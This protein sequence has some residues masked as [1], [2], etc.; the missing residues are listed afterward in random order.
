MSR[1]GFDDGKD[2]PLLHP[3]HLSLHWQSLEHQESDRMIASMNDLKEVFESDLLQTTCTDSGELL[4]LWSCVAGYAESLA[5]HKQQRYHIFPLPFEALQRL[6]RKEFTPKMN[7]SSS[8]ESTSHR[9]IVKTVA[10]IIWSHTLTKPNTRDEIHANSVY[11][12]LRGRIDRKSLDCFGAALTTIAGCHIRGLTSSLL[13]LSEDHAYERHVLESGAIGTCE[14]AVPGTT[15]A[16]QAKRGREIAETFPKDALLTPQTS[17][18]YMASNPVVC[19]SIPMMLV[20]VI[21]NINCT[22]EKQQSNKKCLASGQLYDFKRDMLWILYDQGHM[23]K[24]PFGLLELG[25]CEEHRGS[26][27]SEEWVKV[28][29]IPELILLNEKLYWDA[30]H[31]NKKFYDE[32]QVYPYFCKSFHYGRV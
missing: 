1:V 8:I 26:S 29:Q 10:N 28:D 17:W 9:E 12:W 25:D 21:A 32:A 2:V 4:A 15:K 11:V 3:P 18:L 27:R 20:A 16:A 14:V 13:A 30:I 22:I 24:F 23:A 31:I 19:D 5:T 7:F 6:I